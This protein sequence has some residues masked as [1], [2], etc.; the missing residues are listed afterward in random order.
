[1]GEFLLKIA[2]VTDRSRAGLIP[3]EESKKEDQQKLFTVASVMEILSKEYECIS[4]VMDSNIIN[5]LKSEKVDMVFNLCNGIN[6]FSRLAQLP[7]MLESANIP[8]T[9]SAVLA[10]AL[11]I[12]KMYSCTIFKSN[13]IPTPDFLAIYN[14]DDLEN[15]GIDYPI[16]V[17]PND[18]GSS[19]GIH[20]DSL[21]FNKEDLYKKV[22]QELKI[23]NPPIILNEFIKGR[24][25]SIGILGNGDDTVILPIQ[26][27]D[28]SNLP[29]DLLKFYSFEIKSY[30]KSHTVYHIPAKLTTEEKMSIESVA[31]KAYNS[32]MLKD[33]ARV[34]II[35]KDGIPY[36]LEINSLPGL[37]RGTSALYRMAEEMDL[38]YEGLI[39]KIVDTARKRYNI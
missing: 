5:N 20:Q 26:E 27:V 23:Y 35:L 4:M 31:L 25:F 10:H 28:L 30:Y 6:G 33:Y 24:E 16:L 15:V 3:S 12:N 32:L 2:I 19:R 18:E 22:E 13:N 1:M 11:A 17:K 21:V 34:D 39:L 36:V 9:G 38:G 37:M 14:M 8:Y 7:A 29:D